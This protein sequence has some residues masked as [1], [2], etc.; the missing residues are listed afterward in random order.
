MYKQTNKLAKIA[1][2]GALLVFSASNANAAF[3]PNG[4]QA[5]VT[6]TTVQSWGWTECSGG[7]G[8]TTFSSIMASCNG[9]NVMVGVLSNATTFGI[10]GAGAYANVFAVTDADYYSD[11]NGRILNNWSNG[12]NWYR[13]ARDGS[14]GFTTNSVTALNSAD[15]FLIDG[16]NSWSNGWDEGNVL[17][18]GMSIHVDFAGNIASYGG[19]TYNATG[20]N[21]TGISNSDIRFFMMNN[22]VVDVPEPES[23]ALMGLGFLGMAAIRRKT[24]V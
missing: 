6:T 8:G 10:L 12:L 24:K 22:A 20:N 7:T 2:S 21:Q 1:L 11:D 4:I 9:D 18:Q 19:W 15:I 17:S 5:G 14:F 23:I 13:T 16:I 3:I